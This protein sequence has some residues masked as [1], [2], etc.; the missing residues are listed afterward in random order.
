VSSGNRVR[1]EGPFSVP[2]GL[3]PESLSEEPQWP[4]F[5]SFLPMGEQP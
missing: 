5:D 4:C 2:R 3:L 1:E